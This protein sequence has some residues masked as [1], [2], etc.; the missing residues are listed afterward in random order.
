MTPHQ[1]SVPDP[2]LRVTV[3]RNQHGWEVS[4][5]RDNVVV[6]RATYTD[7][8]RVERAAG[9]PVTRAEFQVREASE[10]ETGNAEPGTRTGNAERGTGN[11]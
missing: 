6:H 1:P 3:T 2:S 7:W 8:H 10:R 4:E 5:E 11:D 9:F